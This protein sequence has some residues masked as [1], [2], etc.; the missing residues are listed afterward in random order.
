MANFNPVEYISWVQRSLNRILGTRLVT[1]GRDSD[2]YRRALRTFNNRFVARA[3]IPDDVDP[4]TQDAL[5]L[6]NEATDYY[7]AWIQRQLVILG[8]T[9]SVD[10]ELGPRTRSAI[11]NFQRKRKLKVDGFVGFGTETALIKGTLQ[12]PPGDIVAKK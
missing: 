6:T 10:G 3:S 7:V 1:S 11:K 4:Q 2:S 9:I 8:H 5:V 12:P